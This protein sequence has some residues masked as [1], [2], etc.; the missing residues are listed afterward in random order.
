MKH[1]P[2]FLK[3]SLWGVCL[4]T[5]AISSLMA[6]TG[7]D[8]MQSSRQHTAT[9]VILAGAPAGHLV[10]WP[11]E[12]WLPGTQPASPYADWLQARASYFLG[13]HIDSQ[14]QLKQI[15]DRYPSDLSHSPALLYLAS[16][17]LN[18]NNYAL[19]LRLLEK[20]SE[21][22][23]SPDQQTELQV[24]MAYALEQRNPGNTPRTEEL[25]RLAGTKNNTWGQLAKLYL[26]SILISKKDLDGAQQLYRELEGVPYLKQE[27]R[28]GLAA[29]EYYRGNHSGALSLVEQSAASKTS[30]NDLLLHIAANSAYRLG[31]PQQTIDYFRQLRS[32]NPQALTPEDYLVLG[33]AYVENNE[34]QQ[35]IAP[36][37]Q[38]T[39][40]KVLTRSAANLYLG[41]VR[42]E[43]GL[44][45]EAIASFEAASEK[46]AAPTV[47]EEAMYE[48]A[49]LMRS[50][51]Q[52]NFGQEIHITEQFLNEFP[53]SV[54]ASAMEQFLVEF[55]LSNKEYNSS[56]A[57]INR[58]KKPTLEILVAKKYVLNKL[59]QKALL[60]GDNQTAKQLLNQSLALAAKDVAFDSE[61]LLLR[62]QASQELR[63]YKEAENDL[64]TYL[65]KQGTKR[66]HS[67]DRNI[68]LAQYHLGYALFAQKEYKEARTHWNNAIASHNLPSSQLQADAQARIGDSYYILSMFS[69]AAQAYQ[70]A[71]DLDKE[72]GAYVLYKLADI[73]G[74]QKRYSQQIQR[75]N[76][77]VAHYPSGSYVPVAL[78]E[79]GR[80]LEFL[81]RKQ[82]AISQYRTLMNR[83]PRTPQ[84][85]QGTL[86]LALLS[87]NTGN[88][89]E[90]MALYKKLLQEAP[91]SSEARIA[92]SSL[93]SIYI[94]EGRTEDFVAF[95]NHLGKGYQLEENE[96]RQLAYTQAEL[97]YMGQKPQTTQELERIR[98]AY[99]NT[100]EAL[101]ATYLLA[102]LYYQQQKQDQALRLYSSLKD[103]YTSL[104]ATQQATV[105]HRLGE[106]S[107]LAEHPADALEAFQQLSKLPI[108]PTQKAQACHGA[109]QAA[110]QLNN[111]TLAQ[112]LAEEGLAQNQSTMNPSLY[113]VLGNA[114][115]AQHNNPK[116]LECYTLVEKGTALSSDTG[117][118]AAV[119]KANIYL[120]QKNGAEKAKKLMDKLVETGTDN[121]HWL[122]KGI[123]VLVDYY[124]QKKDP[125]TAKQYLQ[126]LKKNYTNP[127]PETAQMIQERWNK[128][129]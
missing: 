68:A 102:D 62:A 116:A 42:R 99:P 48:M 61:A 87:Y 118:E 27:A 59:A 56:L 55:Y 53:R 11:R 119:R 70:H 47:R 52:G 121:T 127:T 17:H 120:S 40:G 20:V 65:Q 46:D 72:S 108:E 63:Q 74:L 77:L 24:K 31:Q 92:F 33:A 91:E 90:A 114:Y 67:T 50:S 81:G 125:D 82:E 122:A 80:A 18:K 9:A 36:L 30:S 107:A 44:Y 69:Q 60:R 94:E 83:F 12:V 71:Y 22:S 105:L 19:A 1:Y 78:L 97:A 112:R 34:L 123:L 16:W 98:S 113:L 88:S 124:V 32:K 86:Q 4:C 23:L 66:T 129:K 100:P 126:S 39:R 28:T 2:S 38:A 8:L 6:Q 21:K 49:L 76:E 54:H 128:L 109:A 58:I 73:D 37:L 7:Q 15:V 43:L 41:R 79:K 57:S 45:N 115:L 84:A 101:K 35:S 64:Y 85:R 13:R 26:A 103:S 89:A 96:V 10:A 14:P 93:K 95:S 75:L 25:F 106:L 111:N 117:A 51:G 104:E 29:I 3:L 5:S 110:L